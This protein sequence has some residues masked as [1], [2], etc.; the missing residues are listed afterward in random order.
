[1][2]GRRTLAYLI[3]LLIFSVVGF[4]AIIVGGLLTATFSENLFMRIIITVPL[5]LVFVLVSSGIIGV[6]MKG[7]IGKKVM[8]LKLSSTMGFVT[9][10]R[11]IF[12]DLL[13]YFAFIPFLIGIYMLF[14]NNIEY[15]DFFWNTV[16]ISGAILVLMLGLQV[17]VIM[18]HKLMLPDMVFFTKV[19]N[20]IP[21]AV[22]YDD[23]LTFVK[24]KDKLKK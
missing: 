17:Y 13:K 24:D 8:D 4:V 23:L 12:R 11:L 3:D 7:S 16:K 20:D 1:M 21:T 19:E 14:Q 15:A 5:F 22:E 2:I 10:F 18:K 6:L 9:A